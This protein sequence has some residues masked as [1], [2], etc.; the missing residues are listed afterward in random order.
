MSQPDSDQE[1]FFQERHIPANTKLV[2]FAAL[3]H[4]LDIESRAPVRMPSCVSDRYVKGGIREQDGW[5]LYD[6]RYQPDNTVEGH[7]G[8]GLRHE[9]LDLLVLKRIFDALPEER[10]TKYVHEDQGHALSRR[11]W[12]FYEFLTGRILDLPDVTGVVAIV[13]A[14][15]GKKY[16]TTAGSISKRHKVRDNLLGNNRF[17]PMVRRTEAIEGFIAGDFSQRAKDLIGSVTPDLIARAA[18]FLL[19]A[20]TKASFAIEGETPS[21]DRIERWC[22][23]VQQSGNYELSISEFE[24]LQKILITDYRFVQPGIRKKTVFVGKGSR[25]DDDVRPE[26]I[27][28]KPEDLLPLLEGLISSNAAMSKA[29]VDPVI[30]A[31]AIAFGFVYIHPFEDGNGRLHRCLIHNVLERRHFTPAEM[32]FPV[33]S[34]MAKDMSAYQHILRSQTGPL[35]PFVKWRPLSD[36]IEVLNDTAD[37]YK[38]FDCT[39]TAKFLYQCV[40]KTVEEDVPLEIEYLERHDRAMRNLMNTTEM[41]DSTAD[42]FI[43]FTRQNA[44]KLPRNRREKEF[45][46]LTDE[47]VQSLEAIVHDAFDGFS[48]QGISNRRR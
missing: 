25:F 32:I 17:C 10:L 22:R 34:V 45:Q 24:R 39:E 15:D 4:L 16:F 31:S 33:S 18:S 44:W 1:K 47:E 40:K 21:Q 41:P 30:Q 35:M 42:K 7:L 26:F 8:F 20:D 43:M 2:G 38:Y 36:G 37:L 5:R 23:A 9:V 28:A 13:D 29:G 48:E 3:V 19:L 46:A 27:P 11:A 6:K 14:I 12:F